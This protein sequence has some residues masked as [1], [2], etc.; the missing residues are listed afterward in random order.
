VLSLWPAAL[1]LIFFAINPGM[2][3]LMWTTTAG[4]VLLGIWVV[5]NTMGILTIRRIL[6]IDI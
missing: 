6:D 4:L 5:L 1:G 2:M 3:S